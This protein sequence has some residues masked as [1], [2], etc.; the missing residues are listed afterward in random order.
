MDQRD[1]VIYGKRDILPLF[2]GMA[3]LTQR[4]RALTD[5]R[6]RPAG[7]GPTTGHRAS[8]LTVDRLP[9]IADDAVEEA[10]IIVQVFILIEFRLLCGGERS[11]LE[12]RH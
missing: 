12:R 11:G 2:G 8:A 9:Q 1:D 3:V 4:L 10:Q 6:L 7:N 5:L